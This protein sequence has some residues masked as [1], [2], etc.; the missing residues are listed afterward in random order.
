MGHFPV[1]FKDQRQRLV[2][3]LW[4]AGLSDTGIA[5]RVAEATGQ[6]VSE[7]T[8]KKDK[9][10]IREQIRER[11]ANEPMPDILVDIDMTFITVRNEFWKIY[12]R[13]EASD[14]NRLGA[15]N[16]IVR[17]MEVKVR[18]MQSMG[19][20]K[21]APLAIDIHGAIPIDAASF[22]EAFKAHVKPI[23]ITGEDD[24]AY[25]TGAGTETDD[26]TDDAPDDAEDEDDAEA[27]DTS[28]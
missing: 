14:A 8:I 2:M 20:L 11:L 18:L 22:A 6:T 16:G 5:H 24:P 1:E 3:S 21:Q 19:I 4:A 9:A 15:L 7:R 17:L 27:D 25:N 12:G 26:A 28:A 10:A 13:K 23:D